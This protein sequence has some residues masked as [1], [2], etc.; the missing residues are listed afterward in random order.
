MNTRIVCNDFW[1]HLRNIVTKMAKQ[2]LKEQTPNP[3]CG[4]D[5]APAKHYPYC[6]QSVLYCVG[7]SSFNPVCLQS[8]SGYTLQL[9]IASAVA[10]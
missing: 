5:P 8:C 9:P 7:P 1:T 2:L 6:E 4:P 10:C 3:A